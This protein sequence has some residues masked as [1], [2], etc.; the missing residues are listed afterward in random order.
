MPFLADRSHRLRILVLR[1]WIAFFLPLA[2]CGTPSP[3]V[4]TPASPPVPRTDPSFDAQVRLL[5]EAH[6]AHVQGRYSTAVQLFRRFVE[7]YPGSARTAEA[8]WWLARSYEQVGDLRAAVG[9]YRA[10]AAAE[11]SPAGGPIGYEAHAIRRLDELRQAGGSTHAALSGHVAL[12]LSRA[13]LPSLSALEPWLESLARAGVTVIVLDVGT[14]GMLQKPMGS[15]SV[16]AG[17]EP[18]TAAGVYF[19]TTRAYMV[20]DVLG[21][22]V[23][24]AHRH[25]LSVFGSFSPHDLPWLGRVAEWM[26]LVYNPSD[27]G[28]RPAA[29]LDLFNP[30]VQ[31]YLIGLTTDL[32]QTGV[33][34][35]LLRARVRNGFAYEVGTSAFRGF[36]ASFGLSMEPSQLFTGT[37]T[38]NPGSGNGEPP[39]YWRWVGWKT[40]SYLAFLQ[41][42]AE[43]MRSERASMRVVLEAHPET[44]TDP[45]RALAEYGEDIVEAKQRGFDLV[46]VPSDG[47]AS[48]LESSSK[49]EPLGLV[50]RLAEFIGDP[51]R[52]WTR[53]TMRRMEPVLLQPGSFR[54]VAEHLG[55]TDDT[56]LLLNLDPLSVP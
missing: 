24:L 7:R 42:L 44:L 17:T 51:R 6:L 43:A 11:P 56:S 18:T 40:R 19:P 26:T 29:E 55:I 53:L 50:R 5:K 16:A 34:G 12:A 41:R 47:G 2:A 30:D 38:K 35:V 23:P 54:R 48:S 1:Y 28:V 36:E 25:G 20:E 22:L 8:R 45:L 52:V 46:F 4:P 15:E 3:P 21:R 49:A 13:Q 10:L 39:Y 32:A 9:E 14:S 37:T 33:D 27:H 31:S